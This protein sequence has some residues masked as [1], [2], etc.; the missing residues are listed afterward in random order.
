MLRKIPLD[1]AFIIAVISAACVGGVYVGVRKL[2]YDPDIQINKSRKI[3]DSL[4]LQTLFLQNTILIS[5][6]MKTG[7]RVQPAGDMCLKHVGSKN[8]TAYFQ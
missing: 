7:F 2:M 8:Y 1:S 3:V 4:Q 5:I 6:F